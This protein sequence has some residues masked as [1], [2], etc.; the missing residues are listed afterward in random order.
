[1]KH[2]QETANTF[3]N[4]LTLHRTKQKLV[5]VL[6]LS[7]PTYKLH[8]YLKDDGTDMLRF[9]GKITLDILFDFNYITSAD[10]S[11][12]N[13]LINAIKVK[14]KEEE[15]LPESMPQSIL[16]KSPQ[17]KPIAFETSS[18]A[19]YKPPQYGT[20]GSVLNADYIEPVPKCG[21]PDWHAEWKQCNDPFCEAQ[22]YGKHIHS[23][24]K[25]SV[26]QNNVLFES[27][28]YKNQE[29][30]L[31]CVWNEIKKVFWKFN[32]FLNSL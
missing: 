26:P 5:D 24:I 2:F 12:L 15:S 23:L 27:Q 14:I 9:T 16:T 20:M 8:L 31:L 32:K 6:Q 19:T 4:T 3:Q 30:F 25:P 21:S 29:S 22:Q 13:N 28:E 10:K 7:F 1:M 17:H 11:E 18:I